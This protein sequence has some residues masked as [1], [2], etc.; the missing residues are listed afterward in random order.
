MSMTSNH[1]LVSWDLVRL[2]FFGKNAVDDNHL[3]SNIRIHIVGKS[4]TLTIE[5]IRSEEGIS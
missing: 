2:A 5:G 1:Y 4:R 3:G